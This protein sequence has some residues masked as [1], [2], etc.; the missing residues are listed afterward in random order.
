MTAQTA[1]YLTPG[2]WAARG[3][4]VPVSC[5]TAV[6]HSTRICTSDW[7]TA[8]KVNL[9]PHTWMCFSTQGTLPHNKVEVQDLSTW[10]A[11][12]C[13]QDVTT[14]TTRLLDNSCRLE[15]LQAGTDGTG[16]ILW[17]ALSELLPLAISLQQLHRRQLELTP[18]LSS[19]TAGS[20]KR[21]AQ[22]SAGTLSIVPAGRCSIKIRAEPIHRATKQC[23]YPT[24]QGPV[25][26]ILRKSF[27]ISAADVA[28]QNQDVAADT[29]KAQES[30]P[31]GKGK[32]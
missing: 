21:G 29:V 10:F 9:S 27:I 8:G 2:T 12:H 16:W 5:H 18:R 26:S 24:G 17:H 25:Q 31:L 22:R 4:P 23:S 1:C 32:A 19:H 20:K 28:N 3:P 30:S 6:K 14:R 11:T 7:L 13:H 15:A